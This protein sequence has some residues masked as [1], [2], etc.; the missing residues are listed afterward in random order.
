[1]K[2]PCA[3]YVHGLLVTAGQQ[4][5]DG[6]VL[7]IV[8]VSISDFG[9]LNLGW[10]YGLELLF[11]IE[12]LHVVDILFYC[13]LFF[14]LH[15]EAWFNALYTYMFYLFLY[16]WIL[17][18]IQGWHT[19]MLVIL[20]FSYGD[21]TDHSLHEIEEVKSD[22]VSFLLLEQKIVIEKHSTKNSRLMYLCHK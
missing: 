19:R 13:N 8:K 3:G 20:D 16:S 18:I 17:I 1:M 2:A 15:M 7:F 11:W 21:Q 9:G 10:Q 6:S 22:L 4:V 14:Y 12:W 5:S